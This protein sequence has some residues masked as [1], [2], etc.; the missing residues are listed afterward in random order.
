MRNVS[1]SSRVGLRFDYIQGRTNPAPRL[2]EK[3]RVSVILQ[4]R[5]GGEREAIERGGEENDTGE[6][7]REKGKKGER[8]YRDSEKV[9]IVRTRRDL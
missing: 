7:E 5:E 8:E 4:R 3:Q 2:L 6:R 1:K 9:R